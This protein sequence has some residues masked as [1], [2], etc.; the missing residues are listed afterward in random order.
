M[1]PWTRAL[2]TRG[3]CQDR[4]FWDGLR[5]GNSPSS[6]GTP[7]GFSL[8]HQLASLSASES[9]TAGDHGPK[10]SCK[11]H[12]LKRVVPQL[13]GSGWLPAPDVLMLASRENQPLLL[14]FVEDVTPVDV[15]LKKLDRYRLHSNDRI[16]SKH[17]QTR[18][19]S[20]HHVR[21]RQSP[22]G[23]YRVQAR[24]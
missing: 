9:H 18:V 5:L 12:P 15:Q 13:T 21:G 20:L 16:S 22:G 7:S 17:K 23:V 2:R 14:S 1:T 11:V 8:V 19:S 24:A 4:R 6:R 3:S 10:G